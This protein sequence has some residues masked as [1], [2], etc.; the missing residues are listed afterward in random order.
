VVLAERRAME[1]KNGKEA[2]RDSFARM[3]SGRK[4]T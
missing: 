1:N 4:I 3:A 2:T